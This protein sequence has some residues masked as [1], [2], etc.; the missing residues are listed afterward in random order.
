LAEKW[1]KLH[2]MPFPPIRDAVKDRLAEPIKECYVFKDVTKP[3]VPVIIF[4]PLINN[5]FRNYV[6]PGVPRTTEQEKAF[7]D[8]SIFDDTT[9]YAIWRFVYPHLSFDRLTA[10]MEFN[11][12]NNVDI[13]KAEIAE[14]VDKKRKK[15][16]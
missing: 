7:G 16:D 13:I 12:L 11:I 9:A 14:L 1:A 3:N 10:M 8:F 4:F 2:N 15:S 6:R 5:N